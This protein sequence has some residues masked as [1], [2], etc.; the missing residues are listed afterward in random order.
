MF[1]NK[2]EKESKNTR[3]SGEMA[4]QLKALAATEDPG[5][6]PTIHPLDS[7]EPCVTPV[8]GIQCPLLVTLGTA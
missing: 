2:R 7:S 4:Q 3:E 5:Q 1:E 6:V 8:A